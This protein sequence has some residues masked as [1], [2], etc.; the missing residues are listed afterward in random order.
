[1]RRPDLLPEGGHVRRRKARDRRRR[2]AHV[3]AHAHDLHGAQQA[4]GRTQSMR[5][6]SQHRNN[7]QHEATKHFEMTS[8]AVHGF[9]RR[10]PL[11]HTKQDSP[12]KLDNDQN[13]APAETCLVLAVRLAALLVA[14]IPRSSRRR[15]CRN[16]MRRLRRRRP[17]RQ[18]RAI[19]VPHANGT[20]LRPASHAQRQRHHEI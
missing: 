7:R 5:K 20:K 8:A 1:M 9:T 10:L 3:R 19:G 18:P 13:S 14:V 17:R 16:R 11:S 4:V 2:K 15:A 6:Q 12:R